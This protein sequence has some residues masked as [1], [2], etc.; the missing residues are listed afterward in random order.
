M[1]PEELLDRLCKKPFK[2]FCVRLSNNAMINVLDHPGAVVVG[3]TSAVMPLEYFQN[4]LGPKLVLRWKT[5][6]LDQIAELL[7]L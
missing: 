3:L 4:G 6:E 1:S 2:P 5:I 7:E